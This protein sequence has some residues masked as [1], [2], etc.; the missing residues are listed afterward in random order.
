[1]LRMDIIALI[2]MGKR[3]A[4]LALPIP[5]SWGGRRAG[6]GRKP[7]V[8]RRRPTPHRARHVHKAR[9]PVHLTLRAKAG[10]P[11]LRQ[12][13]LF[14][15]VRTAISAA[16]NRPAF[17]VVHFSVQSDHVHLIVEAADARALSSGSRGLS[18]RI[19]RAVN[20]ALGRSGPFWGDRYH[21][22]ALQTPRE[23]RHGLVYVL[24]NFRKHLPAAPP[25][26]DPC[27]SA[28]WCD[29]L[30]P[31]PVP[32]PSGAGPPPVARPRTWLAAAGWRRHGLIAH[33][34]RP[35]AGQKHGADAGRGPLLPPRP[36]PLPTTSIPRQAAGRTKMPSR[37]ARTRS[38]R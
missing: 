35:A 36:S 28:A 27:S 7:I 12:A 38:R 20:R 4:Q 32:V 22:R 8:G 30:R 34:E 23:V 16:A 1:M 3:P 2:K 33:H 25:E 26:L 17:R 6:A 31:P 5:A 24:M 10:I 37:G 21:T 18:V 15:V 13:R 19:A 9:H 11:S 29:G 14:P